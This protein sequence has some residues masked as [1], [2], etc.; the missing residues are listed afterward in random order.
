METGSVPG[1]KE[2][3]GIASRNRR[4]YTKFPLALE[5]ELLYACCM[6]GGMCVFI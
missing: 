2:L 6:G 4:V 3:L 1:G 5:K